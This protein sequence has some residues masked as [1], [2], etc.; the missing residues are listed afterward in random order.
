MV[1]GFPGKSRVGKVELVPQGHTT[2]KC[3]TCDTAFK[4]ER[5]TPD[6]GYV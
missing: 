2:D 5:L 1:I 6:L 4:P 3:Q